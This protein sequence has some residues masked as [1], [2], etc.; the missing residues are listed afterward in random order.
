MPPPATI[1]QSDKF[2]YR[3]FFTM[4]FRNDITGFTLF[5]PR[6]TDLCGA[7]CPI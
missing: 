1:S 3:G 7:A 2:R 6:S 5:I 4:V